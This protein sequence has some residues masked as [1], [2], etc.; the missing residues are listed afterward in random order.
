MNLADL[1]CYLAADQRLVDLYADPQGW[2]RKAILNI[3]SSGEF[4]CDRTIAQYAS[5]IWGASP[6]P[7]PEI[8]RRIP[9][10]PGS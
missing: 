2:V 7:V 9:T 8:W 4:S 10:D 5:G 3:A 1:K 6:C